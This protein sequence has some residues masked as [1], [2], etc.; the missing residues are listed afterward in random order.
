MGRDLPYGIPNPKV[1]VKLQLPLGPSSPSVSGPAMMPLM[2]RSARPAHQHQGLLV[3]PAGLSSTQPTTPSVRTDLHD[4]LAPERMSVNHHARRNP[5]PRSRSA[6]CTG[7]IA[8]SGTD[9]VKPRVFGD[10]FRRQSSS[11]PLDSVQLDPGDGIQFRR[12]SGGM[13][14]TR[15]GQPAGDPQD[16]AR[17]EEIR[18]LWGAVPYQPRSGAPVAPPSRTHRDLPRSQFAGP[19][20]PADHTC[21]PHLRNLCAVPL[22]FASSVYHL[23]LRMDRQYNGWW[24]RFR[25]GHRK[26]LSNKV[27]RTS[28]R[29]WHLTGY[30]M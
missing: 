4:W 16:R 8:L 25:Y 13:S 12:F 7:Y 1:P 20:H 9:R 2:K 6:L 27:H 19:G 29:V 26:K 21:S 3:Y 17:A 18:H 28:Y 23:D 11:V 14:T 24:V 30:P 15:P 10:E 5:A 22:R